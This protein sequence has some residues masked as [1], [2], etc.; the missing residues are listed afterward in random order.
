[1][2]VCVCVCVCV[3]LLILLFCTHTH[4]HTHTHAVVRYRLATAGED[5]EV[6]FFENVPFKRVAMIKD[7]GKFVNCVRFAPDGSCFVT[8][9]AGG[10]ALI[11]DG[12]AGTL[13]GELNG[14]EASAHKVRSCSPWI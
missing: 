13:K 8:A 7:H 2:C 14:G 11:Y 1:M 5:T 12:T 9:D 10:K 4:T 3:C 6:G